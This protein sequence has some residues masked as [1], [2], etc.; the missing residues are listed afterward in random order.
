MSQKQ[1]KFESTYDMTRALH[2]TYME[3]K[4]TLP[5]KKLKALII[6]Y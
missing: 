6:I 3:W 2:I 5:T 1:K 4:L